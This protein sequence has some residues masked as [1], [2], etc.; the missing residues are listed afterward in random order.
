MLTMPFSRMLI[1]HL[2]VPDRALLGP[3]MGALEYPRWQVAHKSAKRACGT[4]GAR[5]QAAQSHRHFT[6]LS[7]EDDP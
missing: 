6:Y 4:S 2:A 3:L 1:G 7:T 5:A